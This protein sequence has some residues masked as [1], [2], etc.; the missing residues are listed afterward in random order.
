MLSAHMAV[1]NLPYQNRLESI[2]RALKGIPAFQA[3]QL[4]PG[5]LYQELLRQA[6]VI[7]YVDIFRD[8]RRPPRPILDC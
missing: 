3:R 7:S 6:E 8:L 1:G 2:V 4:A 5:I